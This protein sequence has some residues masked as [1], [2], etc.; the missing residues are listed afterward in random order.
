MAGVSRQQYSSNIRLIRVMCSGRVDLEFIQRAFATGQDGVLIGGCRLNECNYVT[1]G[2]FD[3]LSNTYLFQKIMAQ[4]GLNPARLRV[5]FMSG[6]ESNVLVDTVDAFTAA[7]AELGPLG[8]AEGL[9]P[10]SLQFRLAAVLR[11]IP[12]LKLVERERLRPPAKTEQAYRAFWES[13]EVDQL[14][15]ELVRDKLAL[16]QIM[17]LLQERAVTADEIA[18]VLDLE[19]SAVARHLDVSAR[20]GLIRFGE[21]Q[22]LVATT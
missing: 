11:L 6:S 9:T 16:C 7:V 14:F 20:Q 10:E 3:A 8:A 22:Q 18:E 21:G 12:Y 13:D 1:H 5:E 19:P 2:N 17:A 4:I 15:D